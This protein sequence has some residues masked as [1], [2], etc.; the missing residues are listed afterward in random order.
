MGRSLSE[1]VKDPRSGRVAL[2]AHCILNQNSI[3]PGLA[4]RE[5]MVIELVELLNELGIGIIQL[6]CPETL[7]AGL[8]RFWQVKE[9]YDNVGFRSFCRRL[10][11]SIK[12][13]VAEYVRNNYELVAIIGVSGSPSCGV[14]RTTSS[15][16]WLGNPREAPKE[17]KVEGMGV[18]MEELLRVLGR[19]GYLENVALLEIRYSDIESSIKELRSELRRKLGRVENLSN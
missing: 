14:K 19:Y 3:V 2:V 10:A 1:L 9:Q 12:D 8:R 18:F 7:Y 11:V 17:V 13:Y 6:P 5:A 15:N 16:E 4:R